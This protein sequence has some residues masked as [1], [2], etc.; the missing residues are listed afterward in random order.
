MTL[1]VQKMLLKT[2]GEVIEPKEGSPCWIL[3]GYRSPFPF[4][5]ASE[6]ETIDT[7]NNNNDNNIQHIENRLASYMNN[8]QYSDISFIVDKEPLLSETTSR[9]VFPAIPSSTSTKTN[10][11]M[12]C[13]TVTSN[14]TYMLL[15]AHK[16]QV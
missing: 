10:F 7:N 8:Q 13:S 9:E 5:Y 4:E 15:H 14:D 3:L 11:S 6:S 16:V 12:E 2:L 1:T